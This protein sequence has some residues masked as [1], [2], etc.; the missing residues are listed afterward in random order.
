[1]KPKILILASWY[2]SPDSPLSGVFIQEQAEVLSE[3]YEVAVLVPD[4]S[5]WRDVLARRLKP[6]SEVSNGPPFPTFREQTFSAVPRVPRLSYQSYLRAAARGF[7]RVTQTFGAPDLIHAHVVFP[8]GWAAVRLGGEHSI[9]VILT[10]HNSPFRSHLGSRYRRK[11]VAETL[12]RV[13]C[14][15]TVSPDLLRQVERFCQVTTAAVVGNVIRTRFFVPGDQERRLTPSQQFL[16]VAR[17]TPQKGLEY[18]I[19]AAKILLDRGISKFSVTVAGDGPDRGSLLELAASLG[20]SAYFSFLG[21]VDR[22]EV[23][24]LIQE[25]DVFV[26]PSLHETFGIVTAEAMACGKP[27]IATRCGGPEFV[28]PRHAGFLV[29]PGD[30]TGLADAIQSWILNQADFDP[31]LIRRSVEERFGEAAFLKKISGIYEHLWSTSTTGPHN[32]EAQ[33]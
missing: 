32:Q 33:A 29:N 26:L 27:V 17:L 6:R 4:V 2:P 22:S 7:H 8:A 28:V 20:V 10:E 30:P 21:M 5:G 24:R 23:K 15:I 25:C 11:L 18:L 31:Y 16:C 12:R 13:D 9:P 19:R 3:C 14:L 1:M